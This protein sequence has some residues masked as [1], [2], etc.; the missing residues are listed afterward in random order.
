MANALTP[1]VAARERRVRRINPDVSY[2]ATDAANWK[3]ALGTLEGNPVQCIL[4]I[5]CSSWLEV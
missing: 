2:R 1:G 5:R 4:G 3:A